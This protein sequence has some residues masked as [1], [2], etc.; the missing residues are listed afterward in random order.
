MTE[1]KIIVYIKGSS[2]E[3]DSPTPVKLVIS[4]FIPNRIKRLGKGSVEIETMDNIEFELVEDEV[5]W[6]I[7]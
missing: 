1:E 3:I 6:G 7:L 5:L 2:I 4:D